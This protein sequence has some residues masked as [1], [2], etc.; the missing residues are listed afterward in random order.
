MSGAK[1][2]VVSPLLPDAKGVRIETEEH[3]R[4][5]A[6][7]RASEDYY[8]AWAE[9]A[10]DWATR[11]ELIDAWL[12]NHPEVVVDTSPVGTSTVTYETVQS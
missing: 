3:R 5:Y 2:C 12:V 9:A 8:E 7:E 11:S 4:Q 6:A 10:S 1:G